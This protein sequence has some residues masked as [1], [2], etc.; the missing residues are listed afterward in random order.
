MLDG[1]TT[2]GPTVLDGQTTTDAPTVL[3][4]QTTTDA[5]TV[6]DGQTTA[7]TQVADTGVDA[8]PDT[9]V[10]APLPVDTGPGSDALPDIFMGI[11]DAGVYMCM[12][13]GTPVPCQCNDGVDN[14]GDKKIDLADPGCLGPWDNTEQTGDAECFDGQDNDGDG[15]IDNMDPE[16]TGPLDNDESSYGTAIPG[17]NQDCKEDCFFD[18][19]SGVGDDHCEWNLKCDPLSPGTYLPKNCDYDPKLGP[20]GYDAGN[21]KCDP[22]QPQA[23]LDFC[24]PITPPGCDCFGC[25]EFVFNDDAGV[26]HIET[27]KLTST[28]NPSLLNDPVACPRCTQLQSC[29][30]PC[31]PCDVCIGHPP[32]PPSCF[33]GSEAGIPDASAPTCPPG[34]QYCGTDPTSCPQGTTC[35]FGCC[36]PDDI[37]P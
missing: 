23:C 14:D 8:P 5:P 24:V 37:L 18:G 7:D 36:I 32:P 26:Q 17:D 15:K 20:W 1:Q 34:Q 13:G 27:I 33:P 28:C 12:V 6:L 35:W 21:A 22:N 31:G 16:C 10:D 30:R 2:E 4:G 19:N 29:W 3:D 25:C 9:G 11:N